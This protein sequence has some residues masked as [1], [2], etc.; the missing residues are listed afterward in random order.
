MIQGSLKALGLVLL[1]FLLVSP[2][3]GQAADRPSNFESVMMDNFDDP[4]TS[5]WMV[6]GSKF[7]NEDA[8]PLDYQ[9][10]EAW[11]EA[12]YRRVAD[13]QELRSLGIRA[14]FDRRGYN[15][16]EIIPVEEGEGGELVPRAIP[17]QG[18]VQNLDMWVWGSNRSYYV[19][20]QIRDYR[21]IVHT[22]HF[23]D[24]GFRGWNNL[25]VQIPTYIPQEVTYVPQR[26][27]L[28][29]VKLV[30]WTRPEERVDQ[31]YVYLDDLKYFTDTFDDPFDGELL[32]DP[33]HIDQIWGGD[34]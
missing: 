5:Q 13:E 30:L 23:G 11:P 27:G 22:L 2:V 32:A 15:Y 6:I 1:A 25:Q 26:Q 24:I 9:L 10:V 16:L 20:V 12:V 14:A 34:N 28:E 8:Y 21:G 4:E 29:L 19:E 33:E 31:F 17:F 3:F 7:I 18:R